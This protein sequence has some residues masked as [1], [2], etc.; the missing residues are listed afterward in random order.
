M[1]KS[2]IDNVEVDGINTSDYPDFSNAFIYSADYDGK[3]MTEA[4]L[5]EINDDSDYV[6]EQVM[7]QIQ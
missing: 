2:K 5:D 4:Q 6:Y 3:K 7:N 1:D